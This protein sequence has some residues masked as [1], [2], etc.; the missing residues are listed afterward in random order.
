MSGWWFSGFWVFCGLGF[1]RG[2]FLIRWFLMVSWVWYFRV[3]L[4]N[5]PFLVEFGFPSLMIL[6]VSGF[7][8]L[9]I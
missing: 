8:Y 3:G 7:L 5:I 9:V 2:W 4:R 6:V 1:W